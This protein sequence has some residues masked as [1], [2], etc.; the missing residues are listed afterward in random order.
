MSIK[1]LSIKYTQPNNSQMCSLLCLHSSVA[2]I[3]LHSHCAKAKL[4]LSFQNILAALSAGSLSALSFTSCGVSPELLILERL[5]CCIQTVC[6]CV[7]C[8]PEAPILPPAHGKHNKKTVGL[9]VASSCSKHGASSSP[10][11][12]MELPI[13]LPLNEDILRRLG[14]TSSLPLCL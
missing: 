13:K 9:C 8:P 4:I 6:L 3:S 1:L 10:S 14:E 2:L 11:I 12:T 7:P 5:Q